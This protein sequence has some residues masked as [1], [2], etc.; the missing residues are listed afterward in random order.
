MLNVLRPPRRGMIKIKEI[1]SRSSDFMEI[2][3]TDGISLIKKRK[4]NYNDLACNREDWN[5]IEAGDSIEFDIVESV[6]N[7]RI[8]PGQRRQFQQE[9]QK[10]FNDL[11]QKL[12]GCY[13]MWVCRHCKTKGYVP[14]EEGDEQVTIQKRIIQDHEEKSK[15]ACEGKEINIWDHRGEKREMESKILSSHD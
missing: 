4:I 15:H 5:K 9:V 6:I 11:R 7:P 10:Y 8:I 14:Y 2:L 1:L 13:F 3:G 12:T